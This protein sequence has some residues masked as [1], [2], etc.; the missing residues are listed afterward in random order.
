MAQTVFDLVGFASRET[1]RPA[2]PCGGLVVLV[3]HAGPSFAIGRSHRYAGEL[4]PARIVIVVRAIRQGRPDH[5]R[6]R[7]GERVEGR[8]RALKRVLVGERQDVGRV[9][10]LAVAEP[11]VPYDSVV[12][13]RLP[14]FSWTGASVIRRA[15]VL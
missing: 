2:L 14:R 12:H 3:E 15:K 8:A 4:V 5:L 1:V 7:V 10:F 11:K 6:H 13:I 9:R